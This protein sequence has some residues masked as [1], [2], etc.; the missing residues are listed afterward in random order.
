MGGAVTATGPPIVLYSATQGWTPEESRATMQ[1]FFFPNSIFI[2][3]SHWWADM[4]TT[5]VVHTYV[6]TLPVCL[7]ALPLGSA[8]A[9][10]MSRT[11]F[12]KLTMMVLFSAGLL[13]IWV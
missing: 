5:E 1:G 12:E 2:L 8:L 9:M 6:L 13:L 11:L 10:R 4:W 3:S 7:F